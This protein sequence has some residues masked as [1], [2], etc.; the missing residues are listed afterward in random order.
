MTATPEPRRSFFSY[1]IPRERYIATPIL[2][3]SNIAVFLW[4]VLSG[5]KIIDT[6][7]LPLL[8]GGA[9]YG[10]FTLAGDWWRLFSNLFVHTDIIHLV[11]NMF[12][13]AIFG[14]KVEQLFN[15]RRF[16]LAFLLTGLCASTGS[17]YMDSEAVGCGASGAICG[18]CGV[19]A[20][21]SLYHCI[22]Q[23]DRKLYLLSFLATIGSLICY[24]VLLAI[25]GGIDYAAHITGFISGF[26]LGMIYMYGTR[27]QTTSARNTVSILGEL[28][29]FAVCLFSF[30]ALSKN[31][32]DYFKNM[33]YIWN[34]PP[35][36]LFKGDSLPDQQNSTIFIPKTDNDVWRPHYH[37]ST[38]CEIRYPS[39]WVKVSTDSDTVRRTDSLIICLKNGLNTLSIRY[40]ECNSPEE[41]ELRKNALLTTL[42]STHKEPSANYKLSDVTI[43][44]E[45]MKKV[46]ESLQTNNHGEQTE[47]AEK[48]VLYYFS[49][50][51]KQILTITSLA[52]ELEAQNELARIL[53]SLRIRS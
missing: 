21:F 8:K 39:N 27:F 16:C 13:L 25:M 20:S 33:Y 31:I 28:A 3:Y 14:S 5:M 26:L 47:M 11:V 41:F 24:N 44:Q 22:R 32:P 4:L 9:N 7:T 53:A 48:A 29:I 49:E 17:L 51:R 34:N 10:P 19:L 30:L 40:V 42:T 15:T 46:T 12:I 45:P 37:S 38:R 2:L 18:L 1:F 35:E 6:T 23:K 43:N 50:D 36:K 52:Y